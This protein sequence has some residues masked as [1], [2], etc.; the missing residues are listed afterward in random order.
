[1]AMYQEIA[2]KIKAADAILIGASNGLSITE[3]IHLFADNQAL[4]DLLG[5]FK[6]RYGL[7]SLLQGMGARWP[8]EE[9]KWAFWSRVVQHYCNEYQSTPVMHDLKALVGDKEYFI[10]TSNGE[11]HFEKSGFAKEKIY[12]I[13]GTWLALQC[14]HACHAGLYPWS[15]LAG[16]MAAAEQNGRIPADMVPKCPHCGGPMA[17]HLCLDQ[18]FLPD[19]EAERRFQ[20]FLTQYH[21]KKL[22]ILELGIG[23][24]NQLIKAPLMRL[25]SAEAQATYITINL[26]EIF[27]TPDIKDRAYGLDGYLEPVVHELVTCL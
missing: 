22:V 17:V 26:G 5:D 13:E 2:E 12:E 18:N 8:E 24:N 19:H 11:E 16:K 10:V 9:V 20:D 25:T 1:M 15:D 23:K 27:I 3:G 7:R 21:G 4:Q 6:S 14:A